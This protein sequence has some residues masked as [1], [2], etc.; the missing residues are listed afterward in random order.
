MYGMYTIWLMCI[1]K[2]IY[3][4]VDNI[5]FTYIDI[6]IYIYCVYGC[7][8]YDCICTYSICIL[9]TLYYILF[10]C[11]YYNRKFFLA[12]TASCGLSVPLLVEQAEVE[13]ARRVLQVFLGSIC[14]SLRL[15]EFVPDSCG[16][17][18]IHR[19]HIW[20]LKP[21]TRKSSKIILSYWSLNRDTHCECHYV[22]WNR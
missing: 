1:L 15:W 8:V 21:G 5:H 4:Y 19:K 17:W 22:Q 2:Y 20:R 13:V 6:Y 18:L 11:I 3:T 16:F 10:D 14:G 7:T 12:S 9:Q